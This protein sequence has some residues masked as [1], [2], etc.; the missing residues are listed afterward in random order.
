VVE[1][2]RALAAHRRLAL[3]GAAAAGALLESDGV[4]LLGGDPIAE[5]TRLTALAEGHAPV[6]GAA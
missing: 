5:A 2:L 3:G 4:V 1:E 6:G